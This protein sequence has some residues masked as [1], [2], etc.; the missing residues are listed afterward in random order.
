MLILDVLKYIVPV[1]ETLAELHGFDN[2]NIDSF[3][4]VS[5][6]LLTEFTEKIKI[7]A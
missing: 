2:I 5:T 1:C 6:E 3:N 4:S 7:K